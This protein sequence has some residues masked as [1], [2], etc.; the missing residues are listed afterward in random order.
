[1]TS[2]E[3]KDLCAANFLDVVVFW[4]AWKKMFS[5]DQVDTSALTNIRCRAKKRGHAG[6]ESPAHA[7]FLRISNLFN[8]A[9]ISE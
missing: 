8:C 5:T 3:L 4:K 9:T 2:W 7:L 1:M 6:G